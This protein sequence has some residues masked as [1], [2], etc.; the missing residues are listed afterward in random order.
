MLGEMAVS[1]PAEPLFNP[2]V[3]SYAD[4]H[5]TRKNEG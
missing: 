1:G 3:F 4:A 2:Y 5:T